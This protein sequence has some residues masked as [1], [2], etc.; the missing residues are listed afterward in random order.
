[1]AQGPGKITIVNVNGN[2]EQ[3]RMRSFVDAVEA[4]PAAAKPGTR[5]GASRSVDA[6]SV[7]IEQ[8]LLD[9]LKEAA[10]LEPTAGKRAEP[11][12]IQV[13][14]GSKRSGSTRVEVTPIP[15]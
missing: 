3:Q 14:P 12:R 11:A 1:M 5:P 10:R 4:Q 7:R 13:T 15:P 9:T 2:E 6:A 8:A